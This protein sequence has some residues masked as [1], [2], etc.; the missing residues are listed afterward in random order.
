MYWFVHCVVDGIRIHESTN[1]TD[2][3]KAAV[4]A[5]RIVQAFHETGG[6][7]Q[8]SAQAKKSLDRP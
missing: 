6:S 2:K 8:D 7:P 4:A 5:E 3:A 1:E